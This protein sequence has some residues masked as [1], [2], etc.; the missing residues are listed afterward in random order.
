MENLL[1]K[2][3]TLSDGADFSLEFSLEGLDYYFYANRKGNLVKLTYE[4]FYYDD[5]GYGLT[6]IPETYF[7]EKLHIKEDLEEIKKLIKIVERDY[8][9]IENGTKK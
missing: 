1:N 3:L 4:A 7:S 2:I 6:R 8:K 5:V 9:E